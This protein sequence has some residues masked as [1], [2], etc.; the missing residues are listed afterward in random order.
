MCHSNLV[1][2]PNPVWQA[3]EGA[4]VPL[5][6]HQVAAGKLGLFHHLPLLLL[7]NGLVQYASLKKGW[8]GYRMVGEGILTS[9]EDMC[10]NIL[11]FTKNL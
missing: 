10:L 1:E 5:T 3:I 11:Y 4:A 7:N 2:F 8:I 6:V 9:V